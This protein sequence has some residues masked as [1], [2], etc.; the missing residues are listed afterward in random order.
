MRALFVFVTLALTIRAICQS[1]VQAV[2]RDG[3]T[4]VSF[5]EGANPTMTFEIYSSNSPIIFTVNG[6]KVGRLFRDEWRGKILQD[7]AMDLTGQTTT[8][9]VPASGG[10]YRLIGASEGVFVNTV[11]SSGLRY[12]SVVPEGASV[13]LPDQQASVTEAYDPVNEPVKPHFQFQ[14]TINGFD[15]FVFASW[16]MGDNNA[17]NDRPDFPVTANLNK[18]G[19]PYVFML[20]QP[21]GGPGPGPYP[22]SVALH[23]GQGHWWQFRPGFFANIGNKIVS[24][25]MVGPSDDMTHNRLGSESHQMTKWFGFAENFDP[26]EPDYFQDPPAGTIVRNY[27]QRM[28][29]WTIAYLL[30]PSTGLNFDHE[31]ISVYGHS[32]GG[33]GASLYS[34]YRA[35]AISSC[36]MFTPALEA[37]GEDLPNRMFGTPALNL[38]TNI[39]VGGQPVTFWGAFDWHVRLNNARDIPF[40]KVWSGKME[41]EDG[42]GPDNH[43]TARRVNLF[44][45]VNASKLGIHVFWDRRD[46]AVPDWSDEDPVNSWV[47]VGEWIGTGPLT[48]TLRDDTMDQQRFRLHQSFPAFYDSDEDL[49]TAGRQPDPGNGD[50]FN[51]SDFGTW[52]GYI[53]WNVN[54]IVDTPKFWACTVWLVG[55]SPVAIDNYPGTTLRTSMTIRRPQR[56]L[57]TAGRQVAWKLRDPGTG[58]VVQSGTSIADANGVVEVPGLN[59]TKSP[60]IRR[61]EV[62][63]L[64]IPASRH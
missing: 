24:G 9:R 32:A 4:F 8:W 6:L 34:R 25:F 44:H 47:D 48:R 49:N 62:S 21:T 12:Y 30:R 19:M 54:T 5:D 31:K 64:P 57:A 13:I 2:Y 41:F 3:Q 7:G 17:S 33:R 14:K 53:D 51:G 60:T 39:L 55:Q 45:T 58:D 56:F 35:D 46:H 52:A 27:T 16:R 61:I 38:E 37:T 26:F 10:G 18:N 36:H 40:T 11:R 59:L 29:D 15:N 20:S 23:G 42:I 50:P 63:L 43:W 1:N 22:L 28:L